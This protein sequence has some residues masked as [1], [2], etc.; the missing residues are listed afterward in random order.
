MR[1]EEKQIERMIE[2]AITE[3]LRKIFADPDFGLAVKPT[4]MARLKKSA[5]S[6]KKKGLKSLKEVIG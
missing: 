3:R 6:R 2:Q 1:L 4:F 5:V